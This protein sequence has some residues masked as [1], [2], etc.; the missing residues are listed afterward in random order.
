MGVGWPI[1]P[2]KANLATL[3]SGDEWVYEPKWDGHRAIVRVRDGTVDAVSSTGKARTGN[4]PW[5]RDGAAGDDTATTTRS[6]T[7]R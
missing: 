4:W 5:L 1:A 2:M 7:A 6:S 3:P